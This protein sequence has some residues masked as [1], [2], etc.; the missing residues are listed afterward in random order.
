VDDDAALRSRKIFGIFKEV[1][2][3]RIAVIHASDVGMLDVGLSKRGDCD[4]LT[5]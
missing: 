3:L 2:V 5:N 4:M 1:G